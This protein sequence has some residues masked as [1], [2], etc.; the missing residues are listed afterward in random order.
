MKKVF[1]LII[2]IVLAITTMLGSMLNA[3]AIDATATFTES[4]ALEAQYRFVGAGTTVKKARLANG[5]AVWALCFNHA[6]EAPGVNSTLYLVNNGNGKF[7]NQNVSNATV[8]TNGQINSLKNRLAAYVYILDNGIQMNNNYSWNDSL[9]SDIAARRGAFTLNEKYYAT[10][11]A[12][13]GVL[14]KDDTTNGVNI[15]SLNTTQAGTGLNNSL[16]KVKEAAIVLR[17]KALQ[18]KF[19][20]PTLTIN[21]S[22]EM[23]VTADKKYFRTDD[24]TVGGAGYTTFKVSLDNAPAG[25]EI[26]SNNQVIKNLSTLSVGQKF[27]VR[28]PYSNVKNQVSGIVRVYATGTNRHVSVYAPIDQTKQNIIIDYASIKTLDASTSF[29]ATEEKGGLLIEKID[30]KGNYLAG[31]TLVLSDANGKVIEKWTTGNTKETNQK[32]FNNLTVGSKYIISEEKAPEGYRKIAD[33]TITV[34]T[35]KVQKIAIVDEDIKSIKISKQDITTGE[36]LPGAT[37]IVTD[38]DGKE[39]DKWVSTTEPHYIKKEL[40]PGKYTLTEIA[41]PDGYVLTS[42]KITFTV[43]ADGSVDGDIVM[44]NAPEKHVTISKQDATTDKELPGATLVLKDSNGNVVDKW[45][46]TDKPHYIND[47]KDGDY[48]LS[49]TI[50]PEGY[51]LSTTTVKFTIEHDGK[52]LA[53]VVMKNYPSKKGVYI[54]KQDITTGKELPGATL[55]VKDSDG[56]V[57]DKWVSTNKPHYIADLKEGTYTLIEIQSP[58]G[59]GLSE[60]VITFTIDKNGKNAKTVV[61]TN[62]PIPVTDGMN[63]KFAVIGLVASIGLIIFGFTKLNKRA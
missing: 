46:S 32:V 19:V 58:K 47:L 38:K 17:D 39:I 61:M 21:N 20:E 44:K 50:A 3:N 52:V 4:K 8:L 30:N 16:A 59:Y 24:Y 5:T 25:A 54:S 9:F 43:N 62:S 49:E 12:L 53:P 10:Q 26:V 15:E 13:W 48:Y 6:K 28:I 57:V 18:N 41:A 63:I 56:N 22:K 45:V 37:L 29:K 2:S 23:Y 11:L 40:T 7:A 27:Y 33:K 36:E 35:A 1:T 55:I 14:Y 60:E 31:A 42:E 51:E 34:N